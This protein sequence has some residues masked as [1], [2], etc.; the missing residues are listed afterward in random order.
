MSLLNRQLRA[1]SDRLRARRGQMRTPWQRA[2]GHGETLFLDHALFRHA[3]LN[4]HRLDARMWRS[5]QPSPGQLQTI[6]ASGVRSIV[7]LRGTRDCAS[8]LLEKEACARLGLT[9]VDVPFS[10]REPPSA[11]RVLGFADLLE[12]LAYPALMHC[13]SGADRAGIASALYLLLR[14]GATPE[15]AARQLHWRFG[16]VRHSDTGVLDFML[17]RFAADHAR[18]G[19]ALRDWV[20]RGYDPQALRREFRAGRWSNLLVNRL[21]RRE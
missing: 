21:L 7:N 2:L 4:L 18:D 3:Y 9:L 12:T 16:H 6:A 17:A 14:A 15:V 20:R 8:Y 19:I 11:E 5:A 10:S 13:K 1:M